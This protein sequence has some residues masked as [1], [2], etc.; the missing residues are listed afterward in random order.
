[1]VLEAIDVI[2]ATANFALGNAGEVHPALRAQGRHDRCGRRSGKGP[3]LSQQEI[4]RRKRDNDL[5]GLAQ[6][7]QGEN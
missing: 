4:E 7:E 5:C 3:R 1:M 6:R 2:E